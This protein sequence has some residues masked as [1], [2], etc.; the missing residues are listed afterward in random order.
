MV[1]SSSIPKGHFYVKENLCHRF[2]LKKV[3][4]EAAA[5]LG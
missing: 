1:C 2:K 5:A 4:K 3:E